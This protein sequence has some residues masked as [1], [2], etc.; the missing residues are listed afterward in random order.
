MNFCNWNRL[1]LRG[2]CAARTAIDREMQ[3]DLI[4]CQPFA[5]V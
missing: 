5:K 4:N 1:V 2:D 3:E